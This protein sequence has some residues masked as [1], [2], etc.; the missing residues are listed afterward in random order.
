MNAFATKLRGVTDLDFGAAASACLGGLFR[1]I[2]VGIVMPLALRDIR[3]AYATMASLLGIGR[4]FGCAS[5]RTVEH[6]AGWLLDLLADVAAGGD[7][8]VDRATWL[9]L[10]LTFV[11]L[12]PRGEW[13]PA[14]VQLPNGEWRTVVAPLDLSGGTATVHW[15]DLVA[16]IAAGADPT[17]LEIVRIFEFRPEGVPRRKARRIRMGSGLLVD[18][19]TEDLGAACIAD[20]ALAKATGEEWR[21]G[22]AKANTNASCYGALGRVDRKTEPQ[23]V[24]TVVIGPDGQRLT[25]RTRH[26]ETPGPYAF[27]PAAGAVAAGTRLVMAL[28]RRAVL[29][30]GSEVAAMHADS[31]AIPTSTTGG[32]MACPGAPNRRLRV[33]SHAELDRILAWFAPLGVQ[34]KPEIGTADE[35]T[36]GLV[37]GV[38]KVIYA[39]PDGASWRIV[40]SSDTALGGH[41][42][43]PSDHAGKRTPDRRWA[44]SA[45]LQ[46]IAFQALAAHPVDDRPLPALIDPTDLPQWAQRPALRRHTA[47]TPKPLRALRKQTGDPTISPFRCYLRVDTG[48]GVGGP[49]AVGS[50]PDARRWADADFRA[51]GQSVRVQV[52]AGDRVVWSGGSP[53]ASR[54]VMARSI[55]ELFLGWLA[56]DDPSMAGPARGL[57]NPAP[58]RST[59]ELVTVVGKDGDELLAYDAD[60]SIIDPASQRLEYG[61]VHDDTLRDRVRTA[62]IRAVA[63][64]SG[65]A[66]RTI[67]GWVSGGRTN[68][69]TLT[70]IITAL[71]TIDTHPHTPEHP[72][73]T[74]GAP[75]LRPRYCSD[76][77]AMRH[78]R[79]PDAP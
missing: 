47:S 51:D 3:S 28:V 71:Q 19:S 36:C 18:P 65:I 31:V 55:A 78:Y 35:P 70:R 7:R 79:H 73:D 30:A 15:C 10:G 22:F 24:E 76:R 12:R 74:C 34:F 9:R 29:A 64:E 11:T 62:G 2:I 75:T 61:A 72:C 44:W 59:P 20:R 8:I 77:C 52:W 49:V 42:A 40:R 17:A 27:L 56:T 23:P 58:V 66:A 32:W 4:L 48:A 41:V 68:P 21:E 16:V 39:Q 50:W 43:D 54:V 37:V 63:R 67:G 5:I 25:V 1:A 26:P 13:L 46:R 33:L 14:T 60:L 69:H 45:E 38:N 53:R 57:R 6:D